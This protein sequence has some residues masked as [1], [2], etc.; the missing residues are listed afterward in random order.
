M[1]AFHKPTF[2]PPEDTVYIGLNGLE[3]QLII[4][5]LIEFNADEPN[6]TVS[7]MIDTL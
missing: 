4:A 5:A 2:R 1:K 3:V 7:N 6:Q